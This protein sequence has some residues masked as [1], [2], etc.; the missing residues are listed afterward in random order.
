M[1]KD[2]WEERSLLHCYLLIIA[3]CKVACPELE[4]TTLCASRLY[5]LNIIYARHCNAIKTPLALFQGPATIVTELA[6]I[7]HNIPAS[8]VI[9]GNFGEALEANFDG[10]S[11]RVV[12]EDKDL[13]RKQAIEIQAFAANDYV[14]RRPKSFCKSV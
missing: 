12:T 14:F 9:L 6:F 5:A 3:T 7:D 2:I 1:A 8:A 11:I 13:S 4:E 10:I